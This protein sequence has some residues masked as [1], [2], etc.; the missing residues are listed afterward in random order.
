MFLLFIYLLLQESLLKEIKKKDNKHFNFEKDDS[1]K[2]KAFAY[3][4]KKKKEEKPERVYHVDKK[5]F[6]STKKEE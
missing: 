1:K 5:D 6:Y 3:T 2:I 4:K